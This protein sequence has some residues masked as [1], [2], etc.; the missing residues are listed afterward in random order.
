MSEHIHIFLHADDQT[1][2]EHCVDNLDPIKSVVPPDGRCL[3]FNNTVL[4]DAFTFAYYGI[5]N[6]SHIKMCNQRSNKR[7]N[8][9][10]PTDNNFQSRSGHSNVVRGKH[11]E[12][13]KIKD[14]FISRIEGNHRVYQRA[15]YRFM[16]RLSSREESSEIGSGSQQLNLQSALK[17]STNALPIL[18]TSDETKTC[19]FTQ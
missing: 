11:W 16:T 8:V 9:T 15:L 1:V 12:M 19:V 6:G 17:P 4:C 7:L 18:T 5:T 13:S 14:R 2:T 3:I 10:R